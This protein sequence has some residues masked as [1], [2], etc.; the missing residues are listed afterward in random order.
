MIAVRRS[1]LKVGRW[2]R[3]WSWR[4]TAAGQQ[5]REDHARRS[6][7]RHGRKVARAPRSR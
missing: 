4:R 6:M 7:E 2:R 1:W 5:H 3:G